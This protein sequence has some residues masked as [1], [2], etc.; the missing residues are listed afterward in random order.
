M[1]TPHVLLLQVDRF[2]LHAGMIHKRLDMVEANRRV[3]MP[4]FSDVH[5][6]IAAAWYELIAVVSHHGPHPQ[7]GHYT[8]TLIQGN[9]CWRC[10]DNRVASPKD[11]SDYM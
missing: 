7:V 6:G 3:V 2:E 5:M 8:T 9:Q 1:Q 10:D 4:V 11:D